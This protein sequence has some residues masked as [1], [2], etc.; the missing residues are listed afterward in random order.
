MVEL[1]IGAEDAGKKAHRYLRQMLPGVPLSG[2]HKM[3]RT[4]R[5]KCNGR[6]L[7]ADAVL[8]AG[9]VLHLY[10]ADEDFQRVSKPTKKF[11]G[12]N[13][14][15]HV[16]YEDDE[17]L[18]VDKPAGLLVHGA[19][20]EH[21]NTLVNRVLAYLYHEGRFIGAS[22]DGAGPVFTPA[23]V[24]RIDRNTSGLVMFAKTA[25]AARQLAAD[26]AEHRI[27]KWYL[28]IAT[29]T[30]PPEGV[31]RAQLQRRHDENK[32]LV[33]EDGKSAETRY[34]RLLARN[35]T[36]VV[37]V[38][39]VSGR[40]H[41]IRAHFAHIGHPLLGDVKYGARRNPVDSHQWLHAGWLE[42]ADGRRFT[43]PIPVAFRKRLLELGYLASEIAD[44]DPK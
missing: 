22:S 15:I 25:A 43:A 2:I 32:T 20:G 3:L 8:A 6:K 36:S 28:S 1:R 26:L 23:P 41:Q 42:L 35:G 31:I 29:G 13:P 24:N 38:E 10:M 34:Q 30:V 18:V 40:T 16:C 27:R 44:I 14:N 19:P 39:L 11:Q 37:R 4:G 7:K 12:V 5:V 9:D 33:G 21:R 17:L